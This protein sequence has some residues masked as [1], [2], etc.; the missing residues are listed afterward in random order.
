MS[1]ATS[2]QQGAVS[3]RDFQSVF[4]PGTQF[5]AL[6]ATSFTK[7]GSPVDAYGMIVFFF[8]AISVRNTY[9]SYYFGLRQIS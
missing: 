1:L 6:L 5:L 9:S 3:G 7:T 4:G 8:C 2:L